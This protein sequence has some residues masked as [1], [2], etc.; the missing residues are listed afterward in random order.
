MGLKELNLPY[1]LCEDHD[2]YVVSLGGKEL[3][4]ITVFDWPLW[5]L[6]WNMAS[7]QLLFCSLLRHDVRLYT[8]LYL[9]T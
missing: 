4:D 2:T 9:P 6:A 3:T 1:K 8:H 7:V 5:T